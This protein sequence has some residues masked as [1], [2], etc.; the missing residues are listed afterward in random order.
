MLRRK[1]I[2]QEDYHKA[3]DMLDIEMAEEEEI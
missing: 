2:T 1:L 3:I